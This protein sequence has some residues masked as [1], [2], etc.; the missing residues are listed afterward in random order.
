MPNLDPNVVPFANEYNKPAPNPKPELSAEVVRERLNN[1]NNYMNTYGPGILKGMSQAQQDQDNYI[2]QVKSDRNQFVSPIPKIQNLISGDV[3]TGPNPSLRLN[4]LPTVDYVNTLIEKSKIESGGLEDPYA[5]M[6]PTAYNATSAGYNFDRYYSHDKFDEGLG[7]SIYRDNERIYNANSTAWDDFGRMGKKWFGLAY[8]GG[9]DLFTN[10]GK[11]GA[12]G[13]AE[14]AARMEEDLSAAMSSRSGAGAWATNFLANSAYTI[15]I[16]GEIAAEELVLWG[17]TALTGGAASPLAALRT[18]TNAKRLGKSMKVMTNLLNKTDEAKSFWNAAKGL[19]KSALKFVNPFEHTTDLAKMALNKDHAFHRLKDFAKMKR[20]FGAFYKDMRA[21]NA[22]TSESRLEGGF[23]Q[24]KVAN[25]AL[26]AFYKKEGRA[27]NTEEAKLISDKAFASGHATTLINMPAIFLS[28]KLVFGTYLKGF[29]P[30]R[31]LMSKEGL[32]SSLFRIVQNPNWKKAGLKP[33]EVI[34]RG[35]FTSAKRTFSKSYLQSIPS[36]LSGTFSKKGLSA[37]FGSGLRYFSANLA[38]GLQES[39]QEATQTGVTDYYLNQY[40]ADLYQDPH[41][42]AKNTIGAAI[43]NGIASQFS[44][45]GLDVFAQGFL[46]GGVIGGVGNF[47]MPASQRVSMAARSMFDKGATSYSEYV[48]TEKERLQKFADAGNDYIQNTGQYINWLDENVKAQRDLA[49]R[50]DRAE[51]TGDR[52]EAESTKDESLFTHVHTLLASGGFDNFILHL[53]D[54]M[55]LSDTDLSDAFPTGPNDQN[56][57]ST[58]EKLQTAIDKAKNIQERWDRINEKIENPYNPDFFDKTKDPEAYER[59]RIGHAAFEKAKQ[60]AVFYEYSFDRTVERLSSLVNNMAANSPLGAAA[61]SDI[62]ALYHDPFGTSFDDYVK[63]VETEIEALQN[64]TA[65]EKTQ[66]KKKQTQLNNLYDLK[67]L[68]FKYKTH[69]ADIDLAKQ[70]FNDPENASEESKKA[71]QK[72]KD[73]AKALAPDMII[74]GDPTVDEETGQMSINFESEDIVNPDVIVLEHAKDILYEAY[75]KYLKN[76]AD[77]RN[78]F[79][80]QNSI[81][82]SFG[83]LIDYIHLD[84]KARRQAEFVTVLADPM[85]VYQMGARIEKSLSKIKDQRKAL[86][87]KAFLDYKENI[88]DVDDLLQKLADMNVYFDPK[89]IAEFRKTGKLPNYFIDATSGA[90]IDKNSE[91]YAKIVELIKN[92]EIRRGVT[93]NNKPVVPP[94]PAPATPAATAPVSAQKPPE[95]ELEEEEFTEATVLTPFKDLPENVKTLLKQLH[96]EAVATMGANTDIQEWMKDSPDAAAVIQG[97][98]KPK[99]PV[100]PGAGKTEEEPPAETSGLITPENP[101]SVDT[102]TPGTQAIYDQAAENNWELSDDKR[103]YQNKDKTKKSKRVSD[104]K[105]STIDATKPEVIA[106]QNRGNFVDE[107]LRLFGKPVANGLSLKDTVINS[108]AQNLRSEQIKST[109]QMWIRQQVKLNNL[110]SK[111]NVSVDQGFYEDMAAVLFELA[112]RF[113]SYTWHTSLPTMVGTLAG[114]TYGGTID[115][116]LEKDGKYF[117]VDLKTSA[118]IRAGKEMYDL[119]DQIQQN[120][121]AELFE[122][123]TGNPISGIYILNLTSKIASDNKTIQNLSFVERKKADGKKTILQS[124]PR[125]SVDELKGIKPKEGEGQPSTE[126]GVR[127]GTIKVEGKVITM[128]GVPGSIDFTGNEK[129]TDFGTMMPEITKLLKNWDKDFVNNNLV[130]YNGQFLFNHEGRVFV[131]VKVGNFIVPYYFSS[132]GTSGKAIDWHYVFGIDDVYGWIIKGG[133]DE[134]GEVIY[135]KQMQ[136][137]YPKAIAE[138]ERIKKEIRTKLAMTPE[139][140]DLVRTQ[141]DKF[142]LGKTKYTKSLSSIYKGLD[143]VEKVAPDGIETKDN[144]DYLLNAT[145]GLIGLDKPGAPT[146]PTTDAR[147]DIEK[148]KASITDSDFTELKRLAKFFLENPKEPT[149]S[150]SVVTRYPA[151]FKALTDIERRRQAALTYNEDYSSTDDVS[152][153]VPGYTYKKDRFGN[154]TNYKGWASDGTTLSFINAVDEYEYVQKVNAKYN[155]EL[156]ALE[157]GGN[158]GQIATAPNPELVKKAAKFGF[159]EDH[160]KAMSKE[161]RELIATATSKEDVKDLVNKY[162]KPAPVSTAKTPTSPNF[163]V[164]LRMASIEESLEFLHEKLDQLKMQ[165]ELND[166]PYSN[167]YLYIADNLPRITPESARKETGVNVGSKQDINPSLLSKNGVSVQKAAELIAANS[168][169]EGLDLDESFIRDEIIEILKQGKNNYKENNGKINKKDIEAVEYEI[170]VLMDEYEELKKL[171]SSPSNNKA[172]APSRFAGKLIWAQVGTIDPKVFEDYDVIYANDIIDQV[173]K[174]MG[175]T[176]E[177]GKSIHQ[178]I[179]SRADKNEVFNAVRAEVDALKK[180]GKTIISDNWYLQQNADVISSPAPSKALFMRGTKSEKASR[181]AFE[182]YINAN[183]ARANTYKATQVKGWESNLGKGK[184]SV[185][186]QTN[187]TVKE[188]F[189]LGT[190][191]TTLVEDITQSS[192]GLPYL[193]NIMKMYAANPEIRKE[194]AVVNKDGSITILSPEEVVGLIKERATKFTNLP[195]ELANFNQEIDNIVKDMMAKEQPTVNQ[196]DKSS[197]QD[198]INN[199]TDASASGAAAASASDIANAAAS[200]T[201]KQVDDEFEDSL[202]CK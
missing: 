61:A 96:D 193:M 2:A 13:E 136:K 48:K 19:G 47:I 191:E 108:V 20:T 112:T 177:E 187:L 196:E 115:L 42:A 43:S 129:N 7:F 185:E 75:A 133:V 145:L 183:E 83:D 24:N 140:R 150:G 202:G 131:L 63:V 79:P 117:I 162:I 53:E 22:V 18:A 161:E 70:A 4:D 52:E 76:V 1:I 130:N 152:Q 147:A 106:A 113:Q 51:Q 45:Q 178:T 36:R 149:V 121:Y 35:M 199:A 37:G 128:E 65:Q 175:I 94:P 10:W 124:I 132:S 40:F 21:I 103:T 64:G 111:N 58:R 38:E 167:P 14:D 158:L 173:A 153:A 54:L 101:R 81:E 201:Q 197:A 114:D 32:K 31:R 89:A 15:G 165:S 55:E 86:H 73:L 169:T 134:K 156:A 186:R 93:F 41:L 23:A 118:A 44:A 26:D 166:D 97:T 155:A 84:H 195:G 60:V 110:D 200:K 142:N 11:F 174:K 190:K 17:A 184:S 135:S 168:R 160:V 192:E 176:P 66:A 171:S 72:L 138:L 12:V 189:A 85:S 164:T 151:L 57:K 5:M 67:E 146:A 46:M 105:E 139:T 25:E 163:N 3:M 102:A 182:Q 91:T 34:N 122:Q 100:V 154:K 30:I 194:Y 198:A 188:L 87:E 82:N 90:V 8:M 120:A 16:M 143:V 56:V 123:I 78:V 33:F 29:A 69:L 9:A 125:K 71:L 159:T 181:E 49:E 179:E 116:L 39:F 74:Y 170:K 157:G 137:L 104:L 126:T 107:L 141:L 59:E 62:S 99:E 144:Y 68:M 80:I 88:L 77:L 92:E 50:Y 28:N 98:Y 119:G 95:D 109:L 6:R 127:K 27:P 180:Q 172:K 148:E